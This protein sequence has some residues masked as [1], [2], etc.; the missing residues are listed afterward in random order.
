MDDDTP[1]FPVAPG[2]TWQWD[3]GH[4]PKG[5]G[6]DVIYTGPGGHRRVER[7]VSLPYTLIGQE[8]ETHAQLVIRVDDVAS[9]EPF[10]LDRA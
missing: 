10:Y 2:E 7:D 1:G 5:V 8:G 3:G 6:H 4:Q 9:D